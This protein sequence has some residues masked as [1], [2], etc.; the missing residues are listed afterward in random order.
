[1]GESN[2]LIPF[3]MAWGCGSHHEAWPCKQ[4]VPPWSGPHHSSSLFKQA[5]MLVSHI[6][7][8]V[9]AL[10]GMKVVRGDCPI[11]PNER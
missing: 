8:R 9:N 1:M 7:I 11:P 5:G 6:P 3:R 4:V 10:L 2:S